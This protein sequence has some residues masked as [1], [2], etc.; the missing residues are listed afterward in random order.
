[1]TGAQAIQVAAGASPAGVA[2]EV[3][4]LRQGGEDQGGGAAL[5]G[6]QILIGLHEDRVVYVETVALMPEEGEP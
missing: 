2:P 6:D 4:E 3:I 5:V 1:M